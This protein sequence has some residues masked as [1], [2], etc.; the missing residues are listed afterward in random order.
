[1]RCSV[2]SRSSGV[3][4]GFSDYRKWR[5]LRIPSWNVQARLT[6]KDADKAARTMVHGIGRNRGLGFGCLRA[7]S[8]ADS[9]AA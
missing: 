1:M 7:V 2:S 8:V 6:V 3:D 4:N 9:L 5:N